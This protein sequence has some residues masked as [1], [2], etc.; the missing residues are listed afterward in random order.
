MTKIKGDV[1]N[2]LHFTLTRDDI[3]GTENGT[4][5]QDVPLQNSHSYAEIL[6]AQMW[7]H[8]VL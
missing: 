4:S 8:V 6:S 1:S 3:N 5:K 2:G 7:R